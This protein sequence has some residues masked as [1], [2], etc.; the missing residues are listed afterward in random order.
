M[1]KIFSKGFITE[2]LELC[3]ECENEDTDNLTIDIPLKNDEVLVVGISFEIKG[4][5]EN[6]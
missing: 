4:E 5:E 3:I 6:G 2:L 1:N